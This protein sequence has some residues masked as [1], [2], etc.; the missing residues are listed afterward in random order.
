MCDELATAAKRTT[1][2]EAALKAKDKEAERLGKQVWPC[3]GG[4]AACRAACKA[5]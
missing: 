3:G 5:A 2:L 4:R 1:Q